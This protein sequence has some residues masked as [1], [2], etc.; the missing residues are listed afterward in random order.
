MC[1]LNFT[2]IELTVANVCGKLCG[3]AATNSQLK[4]FVS[5]NTNKFFRETFNK[6]AINF[7][8]FFLSTKLHD[9]IRK[10]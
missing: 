7:A 4:A 8:G 6:L 1:L 2:G 9:N 5:T 10:I 3:C